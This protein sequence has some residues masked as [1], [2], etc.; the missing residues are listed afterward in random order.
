MRKILALMVLASALAGCAFSED[1]VDVSYPAPTAAPVAAAGPVGLSVLDQR[2]SD[3]ARISTKI[4]GYGMDMAAIRSNAPVPDIV[5][6]ALTAELKQR[7]FTVGAGGPPITVGVERFYNTF[8]FGFASGTAKAQVD[9]AVTVGAANGGSG[10][11]Q[12]YSGTAEESVMAASGSNAAETLSKALA[13]AIQKM[14]NDNNFLQA[15]EATKTTRT[16]S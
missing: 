1:I 2:T 9:L 3:R 11:A 4:N 13:D 10:F 15:V 14:F 6:D 12:K 16:T 5:R 8:D 7:G